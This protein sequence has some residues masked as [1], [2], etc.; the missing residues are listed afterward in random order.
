MNAGG[1][2]LS[3]SPKLPLEDR[4]ENLRSKVLRW[5]LVPFEFGAEVV[6]HFLHVCLSAECF[7]TLVRLAVLILENELVNEPGIRNGDFFGAK[8]DLVR[9]LG[10]FPDSSKL[11]CMELVLGPVPERFNSDVALEPIPR[12]E[13]HS[14]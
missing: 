8:G 10:S 14:P 13:G 6:Q 1:V 12:T 11:D 9:L 5:A 4:G 2:V 7:M 3:N